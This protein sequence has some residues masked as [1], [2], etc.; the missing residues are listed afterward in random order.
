MPTAIPPRR[1][2]TRAPRVFRVALALACL[3][4]LSACS[5]PE[6]STDTAPSGL[7]ALVAGPDGTSL[8]GWGDS[9]VGVPIQLPDGEAVWISAGRADVLVVTTA[10]G[11]TATSEPLHLDEPIEWRAVTAKDPTGET[12]DGPDYFATW[13]PEGGRFAMLAGD[14]LAGEAV[15]VVLV[16]PSVKS[17][18]EI[19]VDRPVVAA[20]PAWIDD[21]RLVIVT[22]DT[23]A[24]RS[25]IV[26]TTTGEL[27]D[28]PSGSRLLATS[29][30]GRRIATMAEQGASVII[31]DTAGWL[32][33]DGSSIADIAPPGG[34]TTAI[35]FALDAT[36]QRLAV[37]WATDDGAVT[38]AVHDGRS[39]WRRVAQPK[40]EQ[41]R[42][43]VVAWLR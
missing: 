34:S 22:G 30:N 38:L 4:A 20:P 35:A 39:D 21:D 9:P 2:P 18:F 12:P 31:R 42:G 16:D 24:P 5:D 14:L 8:T 3:L 19:P 1:S 32:S 41:A 25:A 29:V 37:A 43:A 17:A 10:A 23:A 33:G 27:S 6:P 40:I 26:D 13:D 15:R 7:L 36:G 28:G 11:K